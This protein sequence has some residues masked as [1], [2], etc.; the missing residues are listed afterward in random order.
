MRSSDKNQTHAR[1]TRRQT[2][3]PK[4]NQEVEVKLRVADRRALLARLTELG[5]ICEGRV[6]EM[7]TLY[8]T[9]DRSLMRKGKLLRI[10]T[11]R[12][13]DQPGT[14][15]SAIT[16]KLEGALLTYKGPVRRSDA[17]AVRGGRRYKIREEREVR[18]ADADQLAIILESLGLRPSFRYEKYRTTYRLPTI[19]NVIL[20]LDETPVGDFLEAEGARAAIDRAA[21]LLG[22]QRE[23]YV[24]K[25]YWDLFQERLRE[26]GHAKFQK[27]RRFP[28]ARQRDMLF[29]RT[30]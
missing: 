29:S 18:A 26:R 5:A 21:Q 30:E 27:R 8:D 4:P 15:A 2:S 25:S 12:Q 17:P 16:R 9:R 10:R 1:R 24:T 6:H 3:P 22:Y 14:Q 7:N 23:D 28:R 11:E 13:A 20:E 19:D